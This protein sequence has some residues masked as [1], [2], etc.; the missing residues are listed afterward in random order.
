MSPPGLEHIIKTCL[1]KEKEERWQSAADVGRELRWIAET[2]S[3]A[4]PRPIVRSRKIRERAL[5][6]LG[7]T[8]VALVAAY[9]GWKGGSHTGGPTLRISI[10][11]PQGKTLFNNSTQ[12]IAIS[13]D[14]T[15]IV[16]SAGGPDRKM[17]LYSRKLSSFESTPI[18]GT[19]GGMEPFF[20]PD[21]QWVGFVTTD[22]M[23]KKAAL[24]G[25]SSVV[26]DT[27]LATGGSW[28]EDGTIY[29]VKSFTSGIYAVPAEG[30]P[31][32]P[33]RQLQARALAKLGPE[34]PNSVQHTRRQQPSRSAQV[35]VGASPLCACRTDRREPDHAK[36]ARR[37]TCP[38]TR[39]PR[40]RRTRAHVGFDPV[41]MMCVDVG[42]KLQVSAEGSARNPAR[43]TQLSPPL[44]ERNTALG[45]VPA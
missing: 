10:N 22:N 12:Q 33:L 21:G 38:R 27:A 25:G 30:G 45:S 2:G 19:E 35:Q 3:Q 13:P 16:Y 11:L 36:S 29:F 28:A 41:N 34:L 1:A 17:Q 4:A 37:R 24:R 39:Q 18:A 9:L 42:G 43:S 44:S 23:L 20:S 5:W 6:I 40:S 32:R 15:T 14:G 8:V 31:Q 26:A 7:A